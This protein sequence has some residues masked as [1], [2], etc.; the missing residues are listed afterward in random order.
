MSDRKYATITHDTYNGRA[1]IVS[2]KETVWK[3][4]ISDNNINELVKAITDL[5]YHVTLFVCNSPQYF[6]ETKP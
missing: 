5:G 6:A 2:T 1:L 4:G 3:S